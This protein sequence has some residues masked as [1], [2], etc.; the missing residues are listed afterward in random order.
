MRVVTLPT[1]KVA[2]KRSHHFGVWFIVLCTIAAPTT[3]YFRPLPTASLTISTPNEIAAASPSVSW[4]AGQVA[5]SAAGFDFMDT[6]QPDTKVSTASIAKVITA[7]CILEKKPL[8]EGESGP[9]LTM[10]SADVQRYQTEVARDGTAFAVSEGDVLTE[11]EMLE[12]ILLPSANNIADSAAIWTFGSIDAYRTY[13]QAFVIANGMTATTIGPDASGYDASTTSTPGDLV[14]LA[15]IALKNPVVME[16]VGKPTA[17]IAGGTQ[18][19]NHNALVGKGGI[20]G[21]KTGRNDDNSGAL[22][23]TAKLG[24][25]ASAVSVAGVVANAGSLS[26][27]LSG[28]TLLVSSLGDE[29][30]TTVVA[31]RNER[32]GTLRTAWGATTDIVALDDLSLQHWSGSTLYTYHET[33]SV[34]GT[35]SETVGTLNVKSD[36]RKATVKIGI[37]SPASG[38]SVLWRITH[39]R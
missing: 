9:T 2:R 25:G 38:P 26:G 35:Q 34:P 5:F 32:V 13:A 6:N 8:A 36:G 1:K 15:K 23:F 10:T 12:A 31:S 4:P 17:V 3:L 39:I 11:Y 22:L 14:K 24:E 37:Q 7:L 18:I 28:T 20:T 29:F 30:P 21:L 16:I 27:A 19:F 33:H